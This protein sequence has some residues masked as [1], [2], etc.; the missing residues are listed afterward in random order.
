MGRA[1]V[2]AEGLQRQAFGQ[3]GQAVNMQQGDYQ[4]QFEYNQEAPYEKQFGID[5]AKAVAGSQMENA[6]LSSISGGLGS[7]NQSNMFKQIYGGGSTGGTQGAGSGTAGSSNAFGGSNP[8]S[9]SGG[10]GS[11]LS[12]IGPLM[13][14]VI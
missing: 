13:E 4:K 12:T 10:L 3:L 11:V 2:Q 6:G 1:G 9:G 8:G 14:A 5:Q 7:Y